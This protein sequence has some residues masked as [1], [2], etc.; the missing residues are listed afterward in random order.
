MTSIIAEMGARIERN[1]RVV[2]DYTLRDVSGAIIDG[3]GSGDE[4]IVYVHGYGMIV[5]GLERALAGLEPGD[6]KEVLVAPEDAYGL[7]DPRL[8]VEVARAALP[9]P[10]DVRVGDEIVGQSPDG[11][12]GILRVIEVAGD[13]VVLDGNHPLAGATLR[14]TVVIRAVGPASAAEIDEAAALSELDRT[15]KTL[16]N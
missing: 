12:E 16:L 3:S 2:L 11:E 4:P 9:K 1:A 15:P 14:Y 8:V 10:D 5:P 7:R 6:T 13:R